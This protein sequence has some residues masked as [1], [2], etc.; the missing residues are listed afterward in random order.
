MRETLWSIDKQSSSATMVGMDRP[1]FSPMP[2]I[3]AHRG[4]SAFYPENSLEAFESAS[5][6]GV[7]VIETDI[8]LTRDGK[9]IIW[10]DESVDRQTDGT[11]AVESF[12]YEELTALDAGFRFSSGDSFPFRGKG[13]RMI[14]LSEALYHLPEMRFNVDLKTDSPLLVDK[15][16]ETVR[17]HDAAE[18]VLGASFHVSN[19]RRLRSVAPQL[20]SGISSR[21][22][23]MLLVRQKLHLRLDR[24]HIG[25]DV[26]QVPVRSGALR[27]V[28][29]SLIRTFHEIGIPIQVW[30]INDSYQMDALLSMGVD[31]IFTD[32]PRTLIEVLSRRDA[33]SF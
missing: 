3:L 30:T 5:S 14:G 21:E 13:I 29:P 19:L 32:D 4:D 12:S 31:G 27:I 2:R 18:R 7:D 10:H 26:L 6:L 20:A 17:A 16:V 25:G 33:A 1:F 23:K 22:V 28:T 24:V 11:G 15:F 9:I 8:H